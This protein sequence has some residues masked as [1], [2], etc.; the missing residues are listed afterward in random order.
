MGSPKTLHFH[1]FGMLRRVHDSKKQI[2]IFEFGDTKILQQ[3]QENPKS[4]LENTIL[5]NSN[6]SETDF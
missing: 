5:G 3:V 2:I 4:F 1:G 6:L